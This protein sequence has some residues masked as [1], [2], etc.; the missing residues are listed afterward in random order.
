MEDYKNPKWQRKRLE[1]LNRDKWTC[2]RCGAKD[3]SLHVHH[4]KYSGKIYDSQGDDL[5]TLCEDCHND[6]GKH[7]K[8]GVW[9]NRYGC[10]CY[11]HCPI[12]GS[13]NTKEKGSYDKCLDCGH[14]IA[15]DSF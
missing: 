7:P 9:W 10:F 5:Q 13:T 14:N 3:K 8:G 15:P 6:L 1:A 2:V 12:C 4:K 11:S